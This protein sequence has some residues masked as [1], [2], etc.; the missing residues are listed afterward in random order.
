M[1]PESENTLDQCRSIITG[2]RV[3][4]QAKNKGFNPKSARFYDILPT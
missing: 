1:K 4:V 3:I 2:H